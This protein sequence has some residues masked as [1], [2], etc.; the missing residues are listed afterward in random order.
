MSMHGTNKKALKRMEDDGPASRAEDS[1]ATIN[2]RLDLLVL[3]PKI[4]SRKISEV[5]RGKNK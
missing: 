5:K 1:L 4:Q 3:V 2:F